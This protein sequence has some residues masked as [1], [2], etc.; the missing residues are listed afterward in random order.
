MPNLRRL[1]SMGSHFVNHAA[2]QPVCGPSRSSLLSGRFPHNTGYLCNSDTRSEANY[3]LEQNNSIGTWMTAAGYHTAFIGKY[4]N[5]LE[6]TVPSGWNYW[7]GFSSSQ[8]TYNYYNSTPWNVTFDRTGTH[9]T[10]PVEWVAMTGVH[11]SDFVGQWGVQQMQ[12]AVAD[13]L[14][15][16]VHLTP[17]MVHYGV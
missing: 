4:V 9:P 10:S 12:K 7:G 3:L 1:A 8:G 11:Q 6:T 2:V 16:F 5:G 14:P 17:L 15:F 13:G